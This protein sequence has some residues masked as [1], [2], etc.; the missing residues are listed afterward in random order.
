M[1]ERYGGRY[2]PGA[3]KGAQMTRP[4][5]AGARV[6]LL[7]AA[8]FL[9]LLGAFGQP[10]LGLIF[11]IAGFGALMLAA[12]LTREGL[13]AE[14]AYNARQ[15]ASRPA[16]PR[17]L[18]GSIL[19]GLGLALAGASATTLSLVE[20]V[21]FFLLGGAL[22]AVAFGPDP[23]KNKAPLGTS[24]LDSDRV[25]RAVTKAEREMEAMRVAIRRAGAPM[26]TRRVDNFLGSVGKMVDAV[27]RDPRDLTRAR[28]YLSVYLAGAREAT[29]RF[30]DIYAR[31]Q[32]TEARAD[33]EVLLSDL[34]TSFNQRTEAMLLEDKS[35]LDVE[36]DVLRDRLAREGLRDK[37]RES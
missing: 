21:I 19:T 26:L 28:K 5:R 33:Y 1:A 2:S 29:E 8:P 34:E 30:A 35:A 7:F 36:I 32:N 24:N 17:K 23:M 25:K 13:R 31:S 27:E 20:P 14:D 9:I 6:N 15:I 16:I 37:P 18:F 4:S 10:P 11:D 12:W 3:Q 22:H